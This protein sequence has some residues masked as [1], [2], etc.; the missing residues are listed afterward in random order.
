MDSS[1]EIHLYSIQCPPILETIQM[2]LFQSIPCISSL[3]YILVINAD[4]ICVRSEK[5]NNVM[6]WNGIQS[7]QSK[8]NLSQVVQRDS[9]FPFCF[10]WQKVKMR[11]TD[12]KRNCDGMFI[13]WNRIC[14]MLHIWSKWI[15]TLHIFHSHKKTTCLW[16][17]T[18]EQINK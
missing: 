10:Y 12:K 13:Y 3:V 4:F 14:S 5:L 6:N 11:S 8:N 7:F 9:C 16:M 15:V 18:N 1:S 2:G 17:K